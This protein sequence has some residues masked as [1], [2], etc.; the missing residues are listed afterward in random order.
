[1]SEEQVPKKIE[2]SLGDLRVSVK[3]DDMD[4]VA[5][6]FE[7]VWS[8]RLEESAEMKEALRNSDVSTQ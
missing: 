8:N 3:G 4:E 2:A 1:M 5:E 6:Q 7:F